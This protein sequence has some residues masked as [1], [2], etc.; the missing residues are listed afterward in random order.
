M[1][2]LPYHRGYGAPQLRGLVSAEKLRRGAPPASR[3]FNERGRGE[4]QVLSLSP[5]FGDLCL[6]LIPTQQVWRSASGTD[7]Y[8]SAGVTLNFEY[9]LKLCPVLAWYVEIFTTIH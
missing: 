4:E 5:W 3:V 8:P 6:G 1:I 2:P 9:P 7:T